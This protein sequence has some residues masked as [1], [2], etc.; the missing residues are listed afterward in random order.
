MM[1]RRNSRPR[2]MVLPSVPMAIPTKVNRE[3]GR[4]AQSAGAGKVSEWRI[5]SA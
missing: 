5:S 1:A 2:T 3:D 4:L